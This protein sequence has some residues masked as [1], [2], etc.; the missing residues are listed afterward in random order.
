MA[1]ELPAP[2]LGTVPAP[3]RLATLTA[4]GLIAFS[5]LGGLL[6][7]LNHASAL[8]GGWVTGLWIGSAV[9]G[10]VAYRRQAA[11]L[12]P[13]P[14][15]VLQA[16]FSLVAL[17]ALAAIAIDAPLISDFKDYHDLAVG[18]LGGAPWLQDGRPMG[19]PLLLAAAYALAG[20]APVVGEW[21]NVL[22]GGASGLALWWLVR[23]LAGPGPA[24][25]ALSLFALWPAHVLMTPV[26]GT[27]VIY[28]LAFLL[29]MGALVRARPDAARWA[30]AAGWA[31]AAGALTGLA[32]YIRP[33]TL[34]LVPAA[35]LWLALAGRR[36]RPVA[37]L[38]GLYL[39]GLLVVLAP[40]AEWNH[41]TQGKWSLSTSAYGGWSLLVGMN[42]R[43][44]GMW[45]VDDA[46]TAE[47]LGGL[48][49]VDAYA[50][51]EGL[52]RMTSDPLGTARLLTVKFPI[53]W[54]MEDFGTYWAL[55][56][57][58]SPDAKRMALLTLLAQTFYALV[59]TFAAWALWRRREWD[60]AWTPLFVG[61]LLL[62]GVHSLLE[63]Q[64]RYHFYWTPLFIAMAATSLARS[65]E[66]EP[67]S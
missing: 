43:H 21:L 26:L 57:A 47:R 46:A 59:T 16:L 4:L 52:R 38:A 61:L 11:G 45:N 12:S 7:A 40:V 6:D 44:F 17:R 29:A 34:A 32:Q 50:K 20:P 63:V 27:E 48:K 37:A 24:L 62:V 49:A 14:A 25:G 56:T 55:G 58:P 8:H 41:R 33:T 18:V 64:G 1:T 28:G 51:A 65:G 19:Y 66:P 13:G 10:A 9:A 3:L 35:L 54:A 36:P 15:L 30:T 42:Q 53:M 60:A 31:A 2:R 67:Y 23:P 5:A 39:V 22:L